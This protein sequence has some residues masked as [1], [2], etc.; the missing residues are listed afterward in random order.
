MEELRLRLVRISGIYLDVDGTFVVRA[1][2]LENLTHPND[3]LYAAFQTALD[4]K[5]HR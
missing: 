1:L 5:R 2:H 4:V 3:H